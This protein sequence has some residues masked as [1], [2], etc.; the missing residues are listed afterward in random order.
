M[1]AVL[2]G[3]LG[4]F[5]QIY[6][7]GNEIGNLTELVDIGVE[8]SVTKINNFNNRL[9]TSI[10]TTSFLSYDAQKEK[11]RLLEGNIDT[12]I[13]DNTTHDKIGTTPIFSE[14][15]GSE[16][17]L[18]DITKFCYKEFY[19][20]FKLTD[21]NIR[22]DWREICFIDELKTGLDARV[23][24]NDK[25][26]EINIS[27]EGSHG[28]TKLL[29]ANAIDAAFF[30]DLQKYSDNF[31]RHATKEEY[32]YLYSKW[33][34]VLGNDGLA[35]LQIFSGQIPDQF[36]TAY[37]WFKKAESQLGNQYS[38]YK[39]VISGHSLGGGLA[40][41]VSAQYYLDT[42]KPIATIAF[43][44]PSMLTQLQE[45]TG[46]KDLKPEDFSHIVNFITEGDPV[47]ELLKEQHIGLS[48]ALP[49][50]LAHNDEWSNV[51]RYRAGL[52][53]YQKATG[54]EDIR[55]DRHDIGQQIDIFAG[56]DFSYPENRVILTANADVYVGN[57]G[58]QELIVSGDGDDIIYGGSA[59]DY[60]CGGSG[61]DLLYGG[62]GN[63]FIVGDQGNDVLFGGAGDDLLYGGVGDDSLD[64]NA[65]NDRLFGGDGNDILIWSGGND[66][67]YGQKGDDTFVLGKSEDGTK[68][69][70]DVTLKFDREESGNDHVLF[71]PEVIDK[72]TSHFTF[73]MSDHILP[74]DFKMNR[75]GDTLFIQYAGD[76]SITIDHWTQVKDFNVTFK[77]GCDPIN[78]EYKV[79]Q[80][81]LVK[82]S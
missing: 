45:L 24:V 32:D 9:V 44:G 11:E 75:A 62:L 27:F 73:R 76:S 57:S 35:D 21:S 43:E 81:N 48:V 60:I 80:G 82:I 30:K 25:T 7:V 63:D 8:N 22:N 55:V 78:T 17:R 52:N 69:S 38:G 36:Y 70:G 33:H 39:Q 15:T 67:L 41:L 1:L 64:G 13:I 31:T 40:Q 59:S 29:S 19:A 77:F 61:N 49:Y 10:K 26:K 2:K 74:S 23:F 3:K 71:N 58:K 4:L 20:A 79:E 42:G 68:V 54:I 65:G 34:N 12:S 53:L 66:L 46:R 56:T 37:A 28:F 5:K 51:L 47:G 14:N 18:A 72:N 50:T 16:T 6:D